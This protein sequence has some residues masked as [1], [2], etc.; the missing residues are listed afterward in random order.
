[1]R[2]L[3]AVVSVLLVLY[4]TAPPAAAA[5]IDTWAYQPAT[6]QLVGGNGTLPFSIQGGAT[7]Y[8]PDG[9]AAIQFTT[10]PSLATST[11]TGFYAPGT[12]DFTYQAVMSMD[13]LRSRST[14]NVFQLGLYNG[15]QIKLQLSQTGVPTCVLHGTGGRIKLTSATPSLNDGGQQHT[16]ACWRT[17]GTVGVTVDGVTTS[18]VFA[19]GNVTPTGHATAGNRSSTGGAADQLF[20][21]IWQL[22]V[23]IG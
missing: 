12:A 17:G 21:K 10:A 20:G 1:M 8:A 14:P 19:L 22:S 13:R 7:W 18:K 16:F 5:P 2:R 3:L 9:T 11:G 23:S 4:A 15:P 6:H